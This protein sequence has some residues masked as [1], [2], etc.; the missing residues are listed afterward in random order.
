MPPPPPPEASSASTDLLR[1]PPS[2]SHFAKPGDLGS[3]GV[4]KAAGNYYFANLARELEGEG[5][6]VG[7]YM[8]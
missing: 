3:Y 5:I 7:L 1:L 8:P 6:H 4:S 2:R